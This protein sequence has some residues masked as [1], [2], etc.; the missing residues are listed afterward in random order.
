MRSIFIFNESFGANN[1]GIG[2]YISQLKKISTYSNLK[3]V[4]IQFS[5]YETDLKVEEEEESI[6]YHIP[7]SAYQDS[8]RKEKYYLNTLTLLDSMWT[9]NSDTIFQFNYFEHSTII[10]WVKEKYPYNKIIF[11]VHF[12]NWMFPIKGN[13]SY[14]KNIINSEPSS[15]KN[16]IEKKIFESFKKEVKI[17]NMVDKV[18][19]LSQYSLK[20]LIEDYKVPSSSIRL[21]V[22]GLTDEYEMLSKKY[23]RL[24]RKKYYYNSSDKIILYVGRIDINKGVKELITSFERVLK[25]APNSKLVIIGKSYCDVLDN[26]FIQYGSRIFFT[27]YLNR[28]IIKGKHSVYPVLI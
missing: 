18:I 26:L 5:S 11:T 7:L 1:Y 17:L 14:F 24:L 28:A 20:L 3:I 27:G 16:D 23:K 21:V 25:F 12:M 4:M 2:R 6:V 9:I 22:N 13:T 19:C 10:E 15:L 8:S